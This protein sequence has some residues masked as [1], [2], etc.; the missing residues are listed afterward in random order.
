MNVFECL[1]AA[2]SFGLGMLFISLTCILPLKKLRGQ[3][4][5]LKKQVYYWSRQMPVVGNKKKSV[6][7]TKKAK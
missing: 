6:K 2:V 1:V 7:S 5:G 4:Y 3:V